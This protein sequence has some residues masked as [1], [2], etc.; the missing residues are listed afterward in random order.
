MSIA[1]E[2]WLLHRAGANF[3]FSAIGQRAK[4]RFLQA[5]IAQLTRGPIQLALAI[6]VGCVIE[7]YAVKTIGRRM[8][9]ELA[10]M[11][12]ALAKAKIIAIVDDAE[13]ERFGKMS[14][15]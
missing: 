7:R 8:E 14:T 1:V 13:W 11:Q 10:L 4:L 5:A 2:L 3:E 9:D 12:N 15:R 6:E